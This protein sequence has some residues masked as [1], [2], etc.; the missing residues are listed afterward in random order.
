MSKVNP[1]TV[2]FGRKPN[3]FIPRYREYFE[4]I[5]NFEKDQPSVQ[6]YL[7]TGI[8]GSGKTALLTNICSYFEEKKDWIVVD[9]NPERDLLSGFASRLYDK[10]KEKYLFAKMNFSLTLYGVS[11]SVTNDNP[12][13]DPESVIERLLSEVKKKGKRVLI[14]IDEVSNSSQMRVF[15]HTFQS[16]LRLDMPVNLI[17]TGLYE[18]VRMLQNEKSLTFLYRVPTIDLKPLDLIDIAKS[19][20]EIFAIDERKAKEFSLLTK[21]YAFAYQ[22]LGYLIYESGSTDVDSKI[23]S[24][25]DDYLRRYAYDKIWSTIPN[26]EKNILKNID[27]DGTKTRDLLEKSGCSRANYASYRERL[28]QRGL[29]DTS[30]YGEVRLSLPRFYEFIK[31]KTTFDF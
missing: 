6:D 26:S 1:F 22:T 4:I 21:G 20:K 8:R 3:S 18:N 23:L 2:T 25:Y 24:D 10:G 7:I 9:L 13:M 28:S 31:T 17:M 19:Y 12:I 14:S 15:A 5:N 11:L 27:G 30:T 16:L 29:L